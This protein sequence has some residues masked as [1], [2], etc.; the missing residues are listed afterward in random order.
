MAILAELTSDA[1]LGSYVRRWVRWTT[2]GLAVAD[3]ST[4]IGTANV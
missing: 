3:I 2:A 1:R 4:P